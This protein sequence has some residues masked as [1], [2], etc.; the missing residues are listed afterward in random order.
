MNTYIPVQQAVLAWLPFKAVNATDGAARAGITFDQITVTYKKASDRDFGS[1]SILVT[2]FRENGGGYYEIAFSAAELNT[3]GT[4]LYLVSGGTLPAPAINP[5]LGKAAVIPATVTLGMNAL[6]G[7]L[8][9][10]NGQAL[11]NESI[12]ARVLSAPALVGTTPNRGGIGSGLISAKSDQ[13]GFFVLEIAQGAVVDV[14]ISAV[15]Y[16]RTLTVPASATSKLFE[17]P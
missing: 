13:N 12:S 6:T 10:L 3:P 15:N 7:Y 14:V 9:D 4:L 1:K 17:I 8:V 11:V 5:Y 2:D 16:R